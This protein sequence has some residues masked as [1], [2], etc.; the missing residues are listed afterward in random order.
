V[1]TVPVALSLFKHRVSFS[2]NRRN[3]LR[4]F[5][6]AV[7]AGLSVFAWGVRPWSAPVLLLS[8]L[9]SAGVMAWAL[10]ESWSTHS[11]QAPSVGFA[12]LTVCVVL[13][14][15]VNWH[16]WGTPIGVDVIGQ[17]DG[18][19]MPDLTATWLVLAAGLLLQRRSGRVTRLLESVSTALLVWIAL[20]SHWS[21]PFE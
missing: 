21:V 5:P 13:V 6:A 8:V 14:A 7:M 19:G 18:E 11:R 3:W 15:G 9:F 12:V 20:T 1:S 4:F 10:G 16:F 2:E 17:R